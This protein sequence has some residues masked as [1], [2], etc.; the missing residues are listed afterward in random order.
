MKKT[1]HTPAHK[2][3]VEKLVEARQ[4]AGITQQELADKL[5]LVQSFVAKCEGGERRIDLIEFLTLAKALRA[6]PELIL[7]A[8]RKA[9]N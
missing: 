9:H 4:A 2:V 8:V 6:D 5:G 1:I 7:R 3:L